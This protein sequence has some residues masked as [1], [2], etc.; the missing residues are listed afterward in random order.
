MTIDQFFKKT[1]SRLPEEHRALFDRF[2]EKFSDK[3]DIFAADMD[4]LSSWFYRLAN[5]VLNELI[6]E[7]NEFQVEAV[8][9][10][11]SVVSAVELYLPHLAHLFSTEEH[12]IAK[13][14]ASASEK[15]KFLLTVM[16]SS[17]KQPAAWASITPET[18]VLPK[19]AWLPPAAEEAPHELLLAAGQ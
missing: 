8:A 7:D 3:Y 2:V 14:E 11:M 17:R 1:R 9:D 12:P 13:R 16:R 10:K 5:G 6:N 4:W 18:E 19:E 15:A